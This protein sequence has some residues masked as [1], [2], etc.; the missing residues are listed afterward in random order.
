MWRRSWRRWVTGT[1]LRCVPASWL[2]GFRKDLG[3][4]IQAIIWFQ[5]S[6]YA[7]KGVAEFTIELER[8]PGK[9]AEGYRRMELRGL[10]WGFY[11]LRRYP[12]SEAW[13]FA[14]GPEE[15]AAA[16]ADALSVLQEYGIPWLEDPHPRS[17]VW[18]SITEEQFAEWRA[19]VARLVA[20]ALTSRGYVQVPCVRP[21]SARRDLCFERQLVPGVRVTVALALG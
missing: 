9:D 12:Y 5:Q 18:P 17:P 8:K 2:Y 7:L 19:A 10:L 13:W 16:F 14:T 11:G 20:P 4:G 15:M 6:Q 3:E 21:Y 1:M